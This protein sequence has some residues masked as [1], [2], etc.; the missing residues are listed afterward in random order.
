MDY[1]DILEN[2]ATIEVEI[3]QPPVILTPSTLNYIL[4]NIKLNYL[5][6]LFTMSCFTSLLF[7]HKKSESEKKIII[8][9]SY[10]SAKYIET[11][12]ILAKV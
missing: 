3:I 1:N 12:P 8:S 6:I 4:D 2:I 10:D 9:P 11:E 7:C 5:L